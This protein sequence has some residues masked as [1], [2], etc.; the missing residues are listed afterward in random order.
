MFDIDFVDASWK[1]VQLRENGTN[2][3]DFQCQESIYIFDCMHVGSIFARV[4]TFLKKIVILFG[5]FK[6]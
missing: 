6:K 4:W 3:I 2:M 5:N 1:P